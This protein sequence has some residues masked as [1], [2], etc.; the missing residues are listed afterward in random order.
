MGCGPGPIGQAPPAGSAHLFAQR[1]KFAFQFPL[2]S[3]HL[4]LILVLL[5]KL[6]FHLFQLECRGNR[7]PS[8]PSMPGTSWSPFL[9]DP[10][11]PPATTTL[12]KLGAG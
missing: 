7:G 8:V 6:H 4:L 9:G 5:L 10:I 1:G 12:G 11:P 2:L 3:Q